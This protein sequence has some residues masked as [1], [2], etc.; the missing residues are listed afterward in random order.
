MYAKT[1]SI[2]TN[3]ATMTPVPGTGGKEM[4]MM[5]DIGWRGHY[6]GDEHRWIV[7]SLWCDLGALRTR[8]SIVAC[9]SPHFDVCAVPIRHE[10]RSPHAL[11]K[12]RQD[13]WEI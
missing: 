13:K 4:I 10:N 11:D 8:Q 6:E 1:A 12:S 9:R 3:P 5:T 7:N 2:A